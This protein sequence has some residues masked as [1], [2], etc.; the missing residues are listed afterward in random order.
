MGQQCGGKNEMVDAHDGASIPNPMAGGKHNQEG[1][2]H[3]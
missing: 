1:E 3:G 2:P